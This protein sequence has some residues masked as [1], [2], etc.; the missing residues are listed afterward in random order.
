MKREPVVLNFVCVCVCMFVACTKIA[1]CAGEVTCSSASNQKCAKCKDGYF[2]NQNKDA[3]LNGE[4]RRHVGHGWD[5]FVVE[6][7]CTL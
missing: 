5:V 6:V 7:T 1:N 4:L 2:L 3:C